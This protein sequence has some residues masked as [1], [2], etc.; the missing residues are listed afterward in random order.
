MGGVGASGGSWCK[1]GEL[2]RVMRVGVNERV[3]TSGASWSI[4]TSM[5]LEIRSRSIL[6]FY[7]VEGSHII[8]G[9][10]HN[11]IQKNASLGI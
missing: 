7:L 11:V 5:T 8:G 2:V 9:W 10:S 1:W 4:L 6:Q 3:G